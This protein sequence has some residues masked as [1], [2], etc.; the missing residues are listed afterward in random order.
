MSKYF[1]GPVDCV[2]FELISSSFHVFG[3]IL[4]DL[5][6]R[7]ITNHSNGIYFVKVEAR[8]IILPVLL[9]SFFGERG[10]GRRLTLVG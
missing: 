5:D 1:L 8:V 2:F 10:E 9:Y 3:G 6:N 4:Y 7:V